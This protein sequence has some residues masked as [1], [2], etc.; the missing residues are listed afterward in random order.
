MSRAY[1]VTPLIRE[2][3]IVDSANAPFDTGEDGWSIYENEKTARE[4]LDLYPNDHADE[5]HQ[6]GA[7]LGDGAEGDRTLAP[8]SKVSARPL[9]TQPQAVVKARPGG[10][11]VSLAR[12]VWPPGVLVRYSRQARSNN[13]GAKLAAPRRSRQT[14]RFA[15]PE[16]ADT[17]RSDG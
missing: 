6:S 2:W 4:M 7:I 3:R 9:G 15:M 17:S 1:R 11:A 5:V 10:H 8:D 16:V 14:T 13:A 12:T